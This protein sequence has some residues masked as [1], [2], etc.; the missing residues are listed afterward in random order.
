MGTYWRVGAVVRDAGAEER[1]RLRVEAVCADIVRQ[2]SQWDPDSE[3]SQYNEGAPGSAHHIS[4]GFA[5]VLDCALIVA[6]RSGGVF[7][8]ALGRSADAWGFGPGPEPTALPAFSKPRDG[9]RDID[10]DRDTCTL[11]QPGGVELDLSGIAK[12]FAVDAVL[13]ALIDEG[14]VSAI[15]EIGGELSGYGV[16][17]DGLPW[18]VDLEPVPDSNEALQRVALCGWS[19]ATSGDWQRRR[20]VGERSWSHTLAP[21]AGKPVEGGNRAA[22]VLHPSCMQAD[23]LATVL[24]VL[25]A[26]QGIAFADRY[27]LAARIVRPDGSAAYSTAWRECRAPAEGDES[28]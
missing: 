18:W 3:L 23:A 13:A 8:P 22:T 1:L 10:F 7:D 12:G 4:F 6:E 28:E 16:K 5:A 27:Q 9:W 19:V 20:S 2:M 25:E 15:A 26:D 17:P 24:M 11:H 21:D 14:A